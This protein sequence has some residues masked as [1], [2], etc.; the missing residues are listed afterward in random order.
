MPFDTT[1]FVLASIKEVVKT[2]LEAVLL[3]FLVMYLFLQN[4]RATLIPTIAVPIVLLGTFAVLAALGYSI[5]ML[6]MFAMVLAIGL[7]VD[8]AIV[9]V[10]NV[11]RLMSEEGLTPLEATR[12]SMDQITGALVAVGMILAA[13][14]VPM[15]FLGGSTGV[16]YRQFSATIVSAIA[17]SVVVAIVLTPALCATM[18]HED[19]EGAP[20]LRY[21]L[22]RLVQ[23]GLR[24][25]QRPLPE[26]GA[27]HH[28]AA[29]KR[30][31]AAFLAMAAVMVVLFL[32]IPTAFLPAEDQ[33]IMFAQVQGP[34]GATQERTMEVMKQIEQHFLENEKEAVVSLF[35][36]Q[37]FSFGGV[38]QNTGVAF[39]SLKD[40]SERTSPAQSVQAIAGRA[41]GRFMQIK[42][43]FV[44]A[45]APPPVPELGVAGGYAFYLKDTV[46]MG[47]DAL[48]AG[49]QPVPG[50]GR[51]EQAARERAAQR[52]GGHA[53]ASRR[54]RLR[55]GRRPRALRR[56][57]Q[58]DALGGLGQP[59]HRRL[60]RA[61]AREA[62]DRAGRRALPHGAGGLPALVGEEREGRDGALHRLRHHRLGLRLAAP[63]ALQRRA[64]DEHQRRGRARA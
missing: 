19:R 21:G 11:E 52:P 58:H 14:F 37:G 53:A 56:R 3:V 60:Q 31:M 54:R 25:R 26:V 51:A 22:L 57:H 46:G 2:L 49:A 45:F 20:R 48:T 34:V 36:V 47:H 5:N 10:E 7:L 28:A 63:G 13:V 50:H 42:D 8:D 17:L 27:R 1:P 16:I 55:Q 29:P 15:A 64:R 32:R 9:V 33:G 4:F 39:V 44:F 30:F 35:T 6:T 18:L 40:W 12:K 43:A 24:P 41:M 61:R 38:G 59:V 23:Q 62:R